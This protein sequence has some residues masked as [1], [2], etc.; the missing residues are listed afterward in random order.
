MKNKN[1]LILILILISSFAFA[2]KK[3]SFQINGELFEISGKWEYRTQ[4]KESGQFHLT[5]KSEK[6]S[7]LISVRKPENFEFYQEGLTEKELLDK[8]YKW[9][10]DYWASS[11]GVKTEVSEIKRDEENNYIIWKLTLKDMPQN[12][13]KDHTS[14]LL[15]A[16]RNNKLIAINLTNDTDKKKPLTETESIDLLEKIYLKPQ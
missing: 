2:Q 15:Y 14:Y 10:Y 5:N 6:L 16:I 11:N 8:F 3:S 9:D 1:F 12:N 4:L 7:L 13:N